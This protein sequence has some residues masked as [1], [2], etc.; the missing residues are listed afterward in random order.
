[1]TYLSPSSPP[2]SVSTLKLS[3]TL[4]PTTVLEELCSRQVR[5]LGR[6]G[7]TVGPWYHVLKHVD[8]RYLYIDAFAPVDHGRSTFDVHQFVDRMRE[9]I[10]HSRGD[11]RGGR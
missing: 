4:G 10:D 7:T 5:G 1:M 11:G 3:G 2:L 9:L 8:P 6:R